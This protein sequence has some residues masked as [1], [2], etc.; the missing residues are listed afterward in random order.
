MA[1]C[2]LCEE[3]GGE[4]LFR[5]E[6]LRIV[7]VD[8]AQY[9]GFCR[10]IW[11]AHVAEMTDLQPEQRSVLMKTV[12]QVESALREV[13]QA[14]KINLASLGNMVPHLHWHLI[15]RF[16]DDAH[17]PSPVWAAV[18]RQTAD[19]ILAQR[20]ALLPALRTAIVRNANCS[21]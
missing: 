10:V 14:E 20:R 19:D 16:S 18:Q 11:N 1:A 21:A 17:F 15:P 4:V 13:M 7:L 8:D 5:N 2:E 12:C 6:Q 9:P 3:G